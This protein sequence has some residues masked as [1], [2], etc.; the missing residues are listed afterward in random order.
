MYINETYQGFGRGS[1]VIIVV[2]VIMISL[3]IAGFMMDRNQRKKDADEK[4]QE[5]EMGQDHYS[6]TKQ[7]N[8]AEVTHKVR[9]VLSSGQNATNVSEPELGVF[10]TPIDGVVEA[11]ARTVVDP[12]LLNKQNGLDIVEGSPNFESD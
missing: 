2:N 6:L 4:A 5:V 3:M 8:S 11:A 1:I 10:K 7:E 9:K 12:V